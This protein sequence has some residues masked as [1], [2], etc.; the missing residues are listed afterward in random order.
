MIRS[1][2]IDERTEIVAK[3]LTKYLKG[4]DRFAK[5][6]VFCVDIDHAQRMRSALINDNSDWQRESQIC[7]QINRG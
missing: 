3:N 6:I 5:T 1:L 4:F 7:L 2:V